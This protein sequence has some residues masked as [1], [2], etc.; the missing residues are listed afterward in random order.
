LA[1]TLMRRPCAQPARPAH[2]SV[3]RGFTLIE[4][5]TVIAIL[6]LLVGLLLPVLGSAREAAKGS[7]CL[8]HLRQ[9]SLALSLYAQDHDGRLVTFSQLKPGGV[10]WWFGFE[11]GGPGGGS[12][13]P[14]DP[15][16]SPLAPYFGGDLHEGLACPAFP[17]EDPRFTEKFAV[18]SAHYGYNGG[19]VWPFPFAAEPRRLTQVVQPAGVFA[20]ADA[21]H[22]DTGSVF[23]EPHSVAYRR[24]GKVAGTGHYRHANTTANLAYL[25]AH[26]A[27]I[28]PPPTETVWTQIADAPAANL[29]TTDGPGSAY[30]FDTWTAP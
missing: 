30:G 12:N 6:A 26:A 27:A 2:A 11:V 29:D 9:T 28:T 4:L 18:R 3:H 23:Y 14:L 20:F 19:L 22:Q 24:P 15:T 13:R 25:D 8:S 10:A 16:R 7:A 1:A 21:V 5:L 17:A